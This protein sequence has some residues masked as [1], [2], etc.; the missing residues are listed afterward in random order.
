MREM[1]LD[2]QMFLFKKTDGE[3]TLALL[4]KSAE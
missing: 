1:L 2:Q 4:Q 3:E